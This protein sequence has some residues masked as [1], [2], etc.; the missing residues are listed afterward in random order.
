MPAQGISLPKWNFLLQWKVFLSY[1]RV[2]MLIDVL[3]IEVV[4]TKIEH[5]TLI[6]LF[7]ILIWAEGV[8]DT[9]SPS[10]D[11]LEIRSLIFEL[12]SGKA[13]VRVLSH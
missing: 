6:V 9:F 13:L 10:E 11:S 3:Y 7:N 12:G 8:Q 1:T 5:I 2:I 4:R